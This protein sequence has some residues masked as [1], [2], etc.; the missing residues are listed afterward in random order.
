MGVITA[1]LAKNGYKPEETNGSKE[2]PTDYATFHSND[3]SWFFLKA[4]SGVCFDFQHACW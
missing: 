4:A 3:L 2:I 1:K